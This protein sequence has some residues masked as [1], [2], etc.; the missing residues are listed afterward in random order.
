M[1]RLSN[2]RS[3]DCCLSTEWGRDTINLYDYLRIEEL[4]SI[5]DIAAGTDFEI[6]KENLKSGG[7]WARVAT[8]TRGKTT[9]RDLKSKL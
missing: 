9:W 4:L 3:H 5:L 7:Q 8:C 2:P 6:E 1:S